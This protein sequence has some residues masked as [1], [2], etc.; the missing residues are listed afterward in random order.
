MLVR[1]GG[2]LSVTARRFDKVGGGM[3]LLSHADPAVLGAVAAGD[4]T[5]VASEMSEFDIDCA[6]QRLAAR[7]RLCL[8]TARANAKAMSDLLGALAGERR[9]VV[10]EKSVFDVARE[11]AE[12]GDPVGAEVKAAEAKGA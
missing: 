4:L 6:L 3:R 5:R 12:R 11:R 1:A 9:R 8:I 10:L 2:G 7:E